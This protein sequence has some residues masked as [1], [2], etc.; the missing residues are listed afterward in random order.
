MKHGFKLRS[1]IMIAE[2][3]QNYYAQGKFRIVDFLLWVVATLWFKTT[4]DNYIGATYMAG[5]EY[6]TDYIINAALTYVNVYLLASWAIGLVIALIYRRRHI[7][8]VILSLEVLTDMMTAVVIIF[9][10]VVTTNISDASSIVTAV[11]TIMVFIVM[12]YRLGLIKEAF[13]VSSTKFY[14]S[15][16]DK[17]TR[18][19]VN[20][21][22]LNLKNQGV[23]VL[24]N[25]KIVV[26]TRD[27][28]KHTSVVPLKDS[29]L[30]I[31]DTKITSYEQ[32]VDN[33]RTLRKLKKKY[34]SIN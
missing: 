8:V 3:N 26:Y 30:E 2:D 19:S 5:S 28:K 34:K 25:N 17:K 24:R 6:N 4:V 9:P 15:V 11:T 1:K 33:E 27:S 7:K 10:Y 32:L 13:D 31:D 23:H 16:S 22:E 18:I 21:V 12:G 29:S 14:C 20:G